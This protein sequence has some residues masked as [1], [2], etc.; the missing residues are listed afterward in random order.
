MTNIFGDV[1]TLSASDKAK[2]CMKQLV[3]RAF[4]KNKWMFGD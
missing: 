1:R 4:L 2:T 3:V